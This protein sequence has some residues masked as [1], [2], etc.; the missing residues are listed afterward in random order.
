MSKI[1]GQKIVKIEMLSREDKTIECWDSGN[2]DSAV[3]VLENGVR[4]YAS[5]DYEGNG[6]GA[7]FGREGVKPFA[8]FVDKGN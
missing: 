8:L 4:L 7:L 3:L 2:E 1:E 5:C 6:S